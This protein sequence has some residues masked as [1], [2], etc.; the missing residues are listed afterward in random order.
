MPQGGGG[1]NFIG[2]GSLFGGKLRYNAFQKDGWFFDLTTSLSRE[3]S[4]VSSSIFSSIL[5][6]EVEMY[7][8]GIGLDLHRRS[9]MS[10][11]SITF[12]RVQN[13]GGSSQR[14]F[15]DSTTST[16]AR[17]NAERDFAIY[18]TGANHSRYLDPNKIHR[19]TGSVLWIVP[20][21]R[22]VPA[23]MTTFGGMYSVRGYKESGIVADGG[24]LASVQYE[25]D[26]VKADQAKNTSTASSEKKPW[27]RKLAPLAFFDYGQAKMK[28]KVAGEKGVEDLYS[29]GIGGIVEL[30]AH[31]SG[32]VYYGFP[33]KATSTTDTKDGM[34][35]LSLMMRW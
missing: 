35:N 29:V 34:L 17:T 27:L 8:W 20:D 3:K 24:I 32:A 14:F 30:G 11:T 31:F 5:G 21:E 22:L 2:N 4:K 18:T 16:G 15:W 7:L 26:L 13:V 23:K 33:L 19:L 1:I 25:Y 10:N 9:D 6:S 12:D 28:D